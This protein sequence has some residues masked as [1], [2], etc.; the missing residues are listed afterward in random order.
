M[1]EIGGNN[2]GEKTN[3][4]A[5]HLIADIL[6]REIMCQMKSLCCLMGGLKGRRPAC[7][8]VVVVMKEE[9]GLEQICA[10][11]QLYRLVPCSAEPIPTR[12]GQA[13]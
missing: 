9:V 3:Y 5:S 8:V 1:V 4:L 10:S 13:Q 6:I 7:P 2:D 11:G 12:A